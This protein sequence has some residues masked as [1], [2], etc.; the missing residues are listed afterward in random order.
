VGKVSTVGDIG[1]PYLEEGPD[2][3]RKIPLDQ[4]MKDY[5]AEM[6]WDPQTGIPYMENPALCITCGFCAEDC[7]VDGIRRE[8]ALSSKERRRVDMVID[9]LAG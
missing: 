3:G 6:G 4:M 8:V 5:W 9:P 7:P 1:N 2:E